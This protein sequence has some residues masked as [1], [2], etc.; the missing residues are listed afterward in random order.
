MVNWCLFAWVGFLLCLN[1]TSSV[2]GQFP[3]EEVSALPIEVTVAFDYGGD[4]YVADFFGDLVNITHSD[5]Y[6]MM[7]AWSPDATQIAFLSSDS[8]RTWNEAR[9]NVITLSTSEVRSLSEIEFSSETTLTWSPDGQY[10]AATLG[11]IFIVDVE[12]GEDLRLPVDCGTCSVN[13]LPDISGLIFEAGGELFSIDLDGNNLQQL[14]TSPPNASRPALSPV[15]NEV[16]FGSSYEGVH[17]LYSVNLNNL[18]I[19]QVVAL[20]GYEWFPHLWSPDG[21]YVAIGVFPAFRSEVEVPGGADVFIINSDG[22]GMQAITGDGLD[23]L[24]GWANDSQHILYYEGDP[25]S[26]GSTFFAVNISDGTKTRLSNA[27]MDRMCSYGS[28]R[29]FAVRP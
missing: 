9:L 23:S 6:E 3:T 28:C 10:I 11:T 16:L 13:W 27:A 5:T 7:P 26:A 18:M 24:I 1:F 22:T 14:T 2:A 17:G 20:S 4:I 19:D 15:S 29:N 12:S 25:G 21:Q 8:H